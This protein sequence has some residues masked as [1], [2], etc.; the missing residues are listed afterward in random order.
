MNE[1]QEDLLTEWKSPGVNYSQHLRPR[2]PDQQ[3]KSEELRH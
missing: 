3:V 2:S 1:V